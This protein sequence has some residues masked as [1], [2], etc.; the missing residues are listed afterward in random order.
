MEPSSF[1]MFL[2]VSGNILFKILLV[3]LVL[4]FITSAATDASIIS[5]VI[6]Y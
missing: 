1:G 4:L 2:A 5:A 3:L 6:Y